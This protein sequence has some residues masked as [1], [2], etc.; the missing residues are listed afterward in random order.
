VEKRSGQPFNYDVL[1]DPDLVYDTE[2]ACRAVVVARKMNPTIEFEFF[3]AVQSAFY[4]D[5]FDM[6]SIETFVDVAA[7]LNLDTNEFR[8]LFESDELK[9]DTRADFQLANEMG[10]RGFPSVVMRHN[11]KLYMIANGYTT[12]DELLKVIAKVESEG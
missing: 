9:Y 3:K 5:G 12:A 11:G 4:V 1:Q 8:S 10:V 6:R 7:N 2:P